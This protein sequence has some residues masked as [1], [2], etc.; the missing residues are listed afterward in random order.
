MLYYAF[1]ISRGNDAVQAYKATVLLSYTLV[2]QRLGVLG[3]VIALLGISIFGMLFYSLKLLIQTCRRS[4]F[5]QTSI[6]SLEEMPT[7]WNTDV[8]SGCGGCSQLQEVAAEPSRPIVAGQVRTMGVQVDDA[9]IFVKLMRATSHGLYKRLQSLCREEKALRSK[10]TAKTETD[11]VCNVVSS[12]ILQI[13]DQ[14]PELLG[15]VP[16]TRT[17]HNTHANTTEQVETTLYMWKDQW[18]T[19]KLPDS[20]NIS[21]FDHPAPER[22]YNERSSCPRCLRGFMRRDIFLRHVRYGCRQR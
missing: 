13:P 7:S 3:L 2:T 18:G 6:E 14:T 9:T 10:I 21:G 19:V 4:R 16:R 8:E 17:L 15:N 11:L 20:S 22:R 12:P 5:L 1:I